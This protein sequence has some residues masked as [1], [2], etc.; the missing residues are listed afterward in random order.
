MNETN[1]QDE[2]FYVRKQMVE[3]LKKL[4]KQS[5]VYEKANIKEK[6]RI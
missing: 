2:S 5:H 6:K 3:R 4:R 1:T